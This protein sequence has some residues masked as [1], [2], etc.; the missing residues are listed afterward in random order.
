MS[1]GGRLTL[2]KSVLSSMP[3]YL[4]SIVQVP[5]TV[6]L[7]QINKL[8]RSWLWQGKNTNHSGHCAL[9]WDHV[10]TDQSGRTWHDYGG[11]GM[12]RPHS[13]RHRRD[14]ALP[15]PLRQGTLLHGD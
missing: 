6:V 14:P 3:T 13:T 2:L 12:K 8:R 7:K 11:F 4:L 10:S 9:N 1:Q 15:V 5:K